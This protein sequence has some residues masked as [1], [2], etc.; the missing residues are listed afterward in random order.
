MMWRNDKGRKEGWLK[1]RKGKSKWPSHLISSHHSIIF[2]PSITIAP[3]QPSVSLFLPMVCI[4]SDS[5][6]KINSDSE[7]KTICGPILFLKMPLK[8]LPKIWDVCVR[9]EITN[10]WM[11]ICIWF[12]VLHTYKCIDTTAA[13][14]EAPVPQQ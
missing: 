7:Y 14:A 5:E 1:E 2:I 6:L 4:Y 3:V 11:V 8:L 10:R 13:K 12:D 9:L